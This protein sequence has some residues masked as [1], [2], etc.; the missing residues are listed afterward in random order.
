MIRPGQHYIM[1][2]VKTDIDG[3]T[4][5]AGLYAAGEVRL[6]LRPRRQPAG[7]QLAAR[8][9]RSSAAAPANTP[10]RAAL[11]WRMPSARRAGCTCDDAEIA[12]DHRRPREGR[13]VSEIKNGARRDDEQLRRRIPRRA[14]P[15][16][17]AGDDRAAAGGGRRAPR[18]TTAAR[19]STRTCSERSELGFML[20]CAEATV[21]GGDRAQ[22][23]A[24]RA[25]PHRLPRAQ[26]RASGSSTSTS[27]AATTAARDQL[28]PRHDHPVAARGAEVLS[29]ADEPPRTTVSSSR[30]GCAATTRSPASRPT[31]TSTRSS[32]SRTARC[33]RAILQARDRFDGSIGI[34]CSCRAGDLR[35]LRRAH[36]RRAR[37]RLPHPP[38]RGARALRRRA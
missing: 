20:D 11:A 34:R 22:G 33:S 10:P 6:R 38:R 21:V 7:R 3:R 37:A 30:C 8:H 32:S 28:L 15:A 24:R 25:V 29:R 35:L 19:S 1:G 31:G 9:A 16:D 27:R 36:Q 26:R 23:V 5:I 18:S 4:P 12:A 2:G 14:G 13:R 17:G